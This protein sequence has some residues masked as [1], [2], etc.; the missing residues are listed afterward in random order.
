MRRRRRLPG[1][2]RCRIPGKGWQVTAAVEAVELRC[3]VVVIAAFQASS[4]AESARGTAKAPAVRDQHHRHAG[5][6][7]RCINPTDVGV[8]ANPTARIR[9]LDGSR[10]RAFGALSSPVAI[11]IVAFSVSS[12]F[13]LPFLRRS[14]PV[15]RLGLRL[16]RVERPSVGCPGI[17][18]PFGEGN[19]AQRALNAKGTELRPSNER[20]TRES[21]RVWACHGCR[22]QESAGR[23][24]SRERCFRVSR[25]DRGRVM[26]IGNRD[27]V[28][29]T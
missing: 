23:G 22:F 5:R 14:T 27:D 7:V 4:E 26:L 21:A 18:S 12:A 11:P 29:L 25:W 17:F 1:S 13:D 10:A 24:T 28:P 9:G 6:P 16:F 19:G 2:P 15:A 3:V 8:Y 20:C